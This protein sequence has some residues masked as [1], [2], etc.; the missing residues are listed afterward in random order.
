MNPIRNIEFLFARRHRIVCRCRRL[1]R[2]RRLFAPVDERGCF[3]PLRSWRRRR[4]RRMRGRMWRHAEFRRP[5]LLVFGDCCEGR[6]YQKGLIEDLNR[7][8]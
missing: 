7:C 2:R 3:W 4:R 6:I 5:S 8:I 1:S